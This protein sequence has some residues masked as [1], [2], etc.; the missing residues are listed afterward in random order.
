MRGH[1]HGHVLELHL[2]LVGGRDGGSVRGSRACQVDRGGELVSGDDGCRLRLGDWSGVV[3]DLNVDPHA[4]S[5]AN[6]LRRTQ[7]P[8]AHVSPRN[9]VKKLAMFNWRREG[10]A[11]A[12]GVEGGKGGRTY[13]GAVM[14]TEMSTSSPGPTGRT[15]TV[16][17]APS[18]SPPTKASTVLSAQAVVPSLRMRHVFMKRVLG[19]KV[20][21]V[22]SPMLTSCT[23]RATGTVVDLL[24][25]Y[26]RKSFPCWIWMVIH[27]HDG[28][29]GNYDLPVIPKS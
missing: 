29:R 19:G 16:S 11:Q 27:T 14:V 3:R 12:N 13:A 1:A 17:A 20:L 6:S 2:E 23:K 7:A 8:I 4:V 25:R 26:I 22:R 9:T 18:W 24:L 28:S 21:P 5:E 15:T 10:D